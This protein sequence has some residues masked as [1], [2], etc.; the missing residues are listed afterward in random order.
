MNGGAI[1]NLGM[2]TASGRVL[3]SEE[4]SLEVGNFPLATVSHYVSSWPACH[5]AVD[6]VEYST[7]LWTGTGGWPITPP[8][9]LP[10]QLSI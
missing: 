5:C 6:Y 4:A 9:L 3:N 1:P 10:V 2:S 7:V 8:Y